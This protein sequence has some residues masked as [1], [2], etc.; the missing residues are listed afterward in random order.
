MELLVANKLNSRT[1][2][3]DGINKGVIPE[4]RKEK[5]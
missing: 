2:K 4:P 5:G 3:R 1:K